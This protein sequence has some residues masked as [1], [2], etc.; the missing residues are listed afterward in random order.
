VTSSRLARSAFR[1]PVN[2]RAAE[3]G[4]VAG[5]VEQHAADGVLVS[6]DAARA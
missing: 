6:T 4:Q 1:Q 3:R 2:D 5:I